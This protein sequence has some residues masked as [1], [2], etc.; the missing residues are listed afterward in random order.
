MFVILNAI[1]GLILGLIYLTFHYDTI[2]QIV[3]PTFY[4]DYVLYIFI[5]IS[6]GLYTVNSDLVLQTKKDDIKGVQNDAQ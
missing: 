3:R 1:I 6:Y 2:E 4:I 5:A